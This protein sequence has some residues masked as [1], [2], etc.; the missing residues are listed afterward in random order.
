VHGQASADQGAYGKDFK[1][2]IEGT[3]ESCHLWVQPDGA[4]P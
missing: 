2:K 1:G 3:V 4:K